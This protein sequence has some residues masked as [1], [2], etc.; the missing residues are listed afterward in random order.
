MIIYQENIF[1]VEMALSMCNF[2]FYNGKERIE[3]S[4]NETHF[5]RMWLRANHH[6]L[7][8]LIKDHKLY[9]NIPVDLEKD[10]SVKCDNKCELCS[11]SILFH[12][13]FKQFRERVYYVDVSFF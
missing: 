8:D 9:K 6:K 11:S 4:E 7:E 13:R 12:F 3:R 1:N 5:Y 2:Q 10:E